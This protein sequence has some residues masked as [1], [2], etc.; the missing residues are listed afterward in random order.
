M[1]T[2][3]H[4]VSRSTKGQQA[5]SFVHGPFIGDQEWVAVRLEAAGLSPPD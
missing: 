1:G 2:H 3:P 4:L 5:M